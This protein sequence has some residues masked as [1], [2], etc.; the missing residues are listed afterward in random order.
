MRDTEDLFGRTNCYSLV[1]GAD[2]TDF[3][4][5]SQFLSHREA[6]DLFAELLRDAAWRDEYLH[7]F[8]RRVRSPRRVCWY[9]EPE[10]G[11]V[12]SGRPHRAAG[13][14]TALEML[15]DRLVIELGQ[16]FNFVLANLYEDQNASMG[17]HADNE[18]ELGTEPVIASVS[19]GAT[20]TLRVRP[21]NKVPGKVRTS[22][23]VP[24]PHGSLLVMQGASQVEFQHALPKTTRPCGPRINLTFR[25]VLTLGAPV[26]TSQS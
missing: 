19:L 2:S 18:P 10:V 1:E 11:Y 7:L 16:P 13:W 20:R 21:A 8:G 24:L 23:P 3:R 15:K 4:L 12:Y 17:W 9:G 22:S 26:A 6:D 25:R 5:L 14:L